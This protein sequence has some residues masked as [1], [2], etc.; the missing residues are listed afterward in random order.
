MSGQ[1]NYEAELVINKAPL[2]Q[3]LQAGLFANQTNR[4]GNSFNRQSGLNIADLE[5]ARI[6][7]AEDLQIH[8]D[9]QRID[10]SLEQ[11]SVEVTENKRLLQKVAEQMRVLGT[12]IVKLIG[13]LDTSK[14]EEY[15]SQGMQLYIEAS[16]Q[17]KLLSKKRAEFVKTILVDKYGCDADRLFTE[18]KGWDLPI[19]TEDQTKN[20][21]VEVKFFSLE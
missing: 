6:V 4:I 3:L 11:N 19:D 7:L 16:A 2:E 10:F 15:K 8:F 12:T 14:V 18:G 1:A 21:R 5:S 9:P 13:H 17:A 20:R